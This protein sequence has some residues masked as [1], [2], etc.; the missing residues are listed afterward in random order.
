MREN[1][2]GLY[3]SLIRPVIRCRGNLRALLI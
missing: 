1:D 3:L 2:D